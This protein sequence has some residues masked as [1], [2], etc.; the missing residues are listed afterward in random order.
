MLSHHYKIATKIDVFVGI[1]K[2]Y[3]EVLDDGNDLDAPAADEDDEDD[4]LVEFTR[5]G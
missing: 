4:A 2:E 5:L 3:R 1:L